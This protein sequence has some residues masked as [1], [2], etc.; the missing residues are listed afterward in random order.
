[1]PLLQ[2]MLLFETA[3]LAAPRE[4]APLPL[5][6]LLGEHPAWSPKGTGWNVSDEELGIFIPF[7]PTRNNFRTLGQF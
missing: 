5:P 1:M 7:V 6:Q 3:L 4:P 2:K